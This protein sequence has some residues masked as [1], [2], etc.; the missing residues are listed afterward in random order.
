ML[1]KNPVQPT[2][3]VE[4]DGTSEPKKT[5]QL[6]SVTTDLGVTAAPKAVKTPKAKAI[7]D[8]SIEVAQRIK[9]LFA[10][11]EKRYQLVTT[12]EELIEYMAARPELGFDTETN[13][14]DSV[15]FD[16]LVGFSIGN[17]KDCIYVPLFHEK[18]QNYTG[19]LD[20]LKEI[21][22]GGGRKYWGMNTKF[23]RSQM[24]IWAGKKYEFCV[25][26]LRWRRVVTSTRRRRLG[27]TSRCAGTLKSGRGCWTTETPPR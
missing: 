15:W 27:L 11:Y 3:R 23:D 24:K 2:K 4:K 9:Q 17:D 14:K 13:G 8:D 25:T 7:S 20:R 19:D 10:K 6:F 21:L 1:I 12:E 22:T 18:G 5:G 16:N 26:P